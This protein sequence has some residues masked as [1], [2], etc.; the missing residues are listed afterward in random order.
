MRTALLFIGL[1]AVTVRSQATEALPLQVNIFG[2]IDATQPLGYRPTAVSM[3]ERNGISD[4]CDAAG[5]YRERCASGSVCA[6]SEYSSVSYE[7]EDQAIT[8]K[9]SLRLCATTDLLLHLVDLRIDYVIK[10]AE[11]AQDNLENTGFEFLSASTAVNGVISNKGCTFEVLKTDAFAFQDSPDSLLAT[12]GSDPSLTLKLDGTPVEIQGSEGKEW[13]S[14][15]ATGGTMSVVEVIEALNLTVAQ[16]PMMRA[17]QRFDEVTTCA[18][19]AVSATLIAVLSLA[20][21]ALL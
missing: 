14:A 8:D 13:L 7:G 3:D 6:L 18:A 4:V 15:F 5:M 21:A 10:I 12:C 2:V 11:G 1:L 19:S 17:M 16:G 20:A 9:Q